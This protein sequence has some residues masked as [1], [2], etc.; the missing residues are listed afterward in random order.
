MISSRQNN[1]MT[2]NK[3]L[4]VLVFLL[5]LATRLYKIGQ[6]PPS[7]YWDEASIGYNAYSIATDLKDEWGNFLPLHFRA[8]GEFKLP[9]YIYAAAPFIKAFGLNAASV[10]LPAVLF[11]LG[12]LFTVYLLVSRIS[13]KKSY[14]ILS[15]FILSVSPWLFIFS[16]TGYEASAGLFFFFLATYLFLFVEKPPYSYLASTFSFVASFYSYNSFRVII[17]IWLV[18][19]FIYRFKDVKRLKKNFLVITIS[20]TIFLASLIPVYRLYRFDAGAIRLSTVQIKTVGEFFGNYFTHLSPSFLF[21]EGDKNPRSQIPGHG[22]LFWI[23]LPLLILGMASILKSRK[24]YYHLP[25]LA[26]VLSFIPAALTIESPHALRSILAAP[27]LAMISTFGMRF[28]ISSFQKYRSAIFGGIVTIYLIC[29]GFY[30]HDFF[31]KYGPETAADWQYQYKQIFSE[32]KSGVV[33]DQY[34]QPYIFALFYQ[35]IAPQEFRDTVKYNP[36]DKWGFSTVSS[37]DGF[38]FY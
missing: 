14:G 37:F 24:F 12:T 17:P 16:R 18:T 7:V 32:Q 3:I 22:E 31:V 26:L 4:L 11:T 15:A 29:F 6:I 38:K 33:T 1:A 25:L 23:D 13:G 35:K 21:V 5:F 27:S 9:V 28:L 19:L 20:A 34:A 2:K 8:F 36:V 30:A 10:R